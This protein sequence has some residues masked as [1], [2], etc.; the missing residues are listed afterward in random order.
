[1]SDEVKLYIKIIVVD[2]IKFIVDNFFI[3]S[4]L[5]VQ[6]IIIN[7]LILKSRSFDFQTTSDVE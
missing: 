6:K 7:F 5:I 2:K 3:W 4:H 1:M